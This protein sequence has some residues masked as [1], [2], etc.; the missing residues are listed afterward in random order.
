ML[1]GLLLA[2]GPWRTRK[3]TVPLPVYPRNPTWTVLGSNLDLRG[4][5][6]LACSH[7]QSK[8]LPMVSHVNCW[9]SELK[10]LTKTLLFPCWWATESRSTPAVPLSLAWGGDVRW[11]LCECLTGRA[12]VCTT[13]LTQQSLDGSLWNLILGRFMKIF[14]EQFR[15]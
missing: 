4:E 6:P 14:V 9:T 5:V 12:P 2:G 1:V 15:F 3:N 11:G 13:H 7:I 8:A 10:V